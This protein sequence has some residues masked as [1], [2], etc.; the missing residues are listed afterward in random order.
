MANERLAFASDYM[1][2]AHPQVLQALA[3]VNEAAHA[4]YG[5]DGVC[6]KA[7]REILA[8]CACPEGEVYYLSGG[9]QA[10]EVVITALLQPWQGVVA[11]ET[12]HIAVHEAGAIEAGGHKVLM[13]PQHD[14]KIAADDLRALLAT[15]A[16]DANREHTVAP[17]MV[18][19][20][21]PTEYGTLYQL[22]EL[23]EI[24]AT[25]REAGLALFVD[26][27]RLAYAL[28]TP[29]NDVSL[30]DL[31]RL[32]D[33]FYIGGT[34]CGTLFG[35]AV[36]IPRTGLIPHFFTIIKQRGALLAKGFVLGAQFD[37]LFADGLYLRIGKT[38]IA[39]A[40]RIKDALREHGFEMPIDSPTNQVF[41]LAG[42][43]MLERLSERADYGFME[44]WPDGRSLVRLA[45]S[46][47]TSEQEINEVCQLIASLA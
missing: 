37:A 6:A 16:A 45:T 42:A 18:Y 13:L 12:G 26:G 14:G 31:A 19:L 9:T 2:G 10:N 32:A 24:S 22:S 7:T 20:S 36:V 34:K 29:E 25:C 30:A 3:E 1:R 4:G 8:T 40:R 39:G 44:S 11:A 5:G 23:E 46:W 17:G 27:A 15:Y 21:Q 33:V 35:E 28:A 38:A 43:S 41:F 47:Y